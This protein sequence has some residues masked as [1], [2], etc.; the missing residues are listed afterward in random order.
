MLILP[1]RSDPQGPERAA[2]LLR[3]Q[4]ANRVT[5]LFVIFGDTGDARECASRADVRAAAFPHSRAVVWIPDP[6]SPDATLT[7][8]WQTAAMEL[9]VVISF[10]GQ[11]VERL[12]MPDAHR[13]ASIERAFLRAQGGSP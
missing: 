10:D 6:A 11:V 1:T 2:K 13:F 9:A 7:A 12:T 5:S 3:E 4:L 8:G